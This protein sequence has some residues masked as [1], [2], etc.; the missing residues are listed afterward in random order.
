MYQK[1]DLYGHRQRQI[2]NQQGVETKQFQ[3]GLFTATGTDARPRTQGTIPPEKKIHGGCPRKSSPGINARAVVIPTN[4]WQSLSRGH[5]D[6]QPR[7]DISNMSAP[8]KNRE[9]HSIS[10]FDTGLNTVSDRQAARK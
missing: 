5:S 8:T 2:S 9:E 4:R 10:I 6:G 1:R 3:A 7:A